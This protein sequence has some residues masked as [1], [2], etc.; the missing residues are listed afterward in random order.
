MTRNRIRLGAALLVVVFSLGTAWSGSDA[1]TGWLE[2]RQGA[3]QSAEPARK[4]ARRTFKF[5]DRSCESGCLE[6]FK[7]SDGQELTV[8]GACYSGSGK[9]AWR[10][11]QEE[12]KAYGGRVVKRSWRRDWH[13]R[14][15]Q[16]IVVLY[17]RD[18][19][20]DKPVKIF[21][22][23]RGDTCFTYMTAGSLD[24][25]LEFERSKLGLEAMYGI[26]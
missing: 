5:V 10:D 2:H 16:R 4:Q 14:K 19:T 8:V 24:L 6:T 22:Y 20:G 18:E 12:I 23:V 15:G 1:A 13:R 11:M 7:S 25:A 26:T 17:P 9:A 3:S 21:W